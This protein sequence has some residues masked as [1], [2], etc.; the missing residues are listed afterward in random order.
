M[1]FSP[2][3]FIVDKFT[4]LA[5]SRG[6]QPVGDVKAGRQKQ[7]LSGLTSIKQGDKRDS[8]LA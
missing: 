1:D 8:M 3:V 2:A 4:V 7:N 6:S 5:N